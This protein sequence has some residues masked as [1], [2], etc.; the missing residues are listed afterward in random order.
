MHRR[1]A[2]RLTGPVTKWFVLVVWL[3]VVA[4]AAGFASKLTEVQNNEAASWLPASAES[5]RALERIAPFQD[6]NAIPT[7]VVYERTSGLTRDD[8]AAAAAQ[9]ADFAALDGVSGEV[10]G[11]VPSA[12]GQAAQS[13]VTFDF[14]AEGWNEMPAAADAL[15]DLAAIDG[16][17]IHI[18]GAG[19]QAADSAEAFAGI[20]GT[21]LLATL[22]VVV[23]ILLLTYRS[24]VLWVLPIVSAVFALFTTE[25]VV[26]FLARYADLTVNGQSQGILTVLVIGAGTDYAL[27]LVA[28]Y[29]E[30][31]RRH[32]DRHVAMAVA[33][34]RATPAIL[35]SA[36]TVS[37]GMLCLLAADMSS[38]AGLG[39]V[40][41]IGV[42]ITFLVMVT[43]LPALLV[44]C[45]R[46]I[47][48]PR[49]P[50]LGSV[51]PTA[52]ACGPGSVGSSRR[53]RA[54][55]GS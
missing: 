21:L 45:G 6:P 4:G 46:W 23:L 29:R 47:F 22:A 13:V 27:L 8:L 10:V 40:N 54:G 37:I 1:L 15:R 44:I 12:D 35:A 39:P 41:A 28:R 19:G 32:E 20:D 31:L 24:P 33:L 11:P 36:A 2:G 43:L 16:V 30:E 48:W 38:T 9:T 55:S 17:T 25:A 50:G 52:A 42:V 34:H 5:T 49:R 51:E 14:G 3:V 18:A 53:D 26:Y 7:V